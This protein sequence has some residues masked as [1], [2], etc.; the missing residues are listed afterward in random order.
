MQAARAAAE[1]EKTFGERLCKDLKRQLTEA[2]RFRGE[3][4][5]QRDVTQE[6][7]RTL[8]RLL[9]E[10]EGRRAEALRQR[11]VAQGEC[12]TLKQK[13]SAEARRP[14][15]RIA[16]AHYVD[17]DGRVTERKVFES[18]S[19]SDDSSESDE[20]EDGCASRDDPCVRAP[21]VQSGF[22]DEFFARPVPRPSSDNVY[23]TSFPPPC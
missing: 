16:V 21:F 13:L 15:G 17:S 14:R 8:K 1:C 22:G 20:S 10:V 7:C 18:S 11:N 6:K 3:A 2:E 4:M 5:R 12:N 23:D 19:D 9:T